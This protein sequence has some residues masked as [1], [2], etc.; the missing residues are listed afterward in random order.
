V[1]PNIDISGHRRASL[2][3]RSLR[4]PG[5]MPARPNAIENYSAISHPS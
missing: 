4:K 3:A 2:A 1:R 5:V